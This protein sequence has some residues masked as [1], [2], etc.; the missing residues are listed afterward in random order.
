MIEGVFPLLS[1][2][3]SPYTLDVEQ[4]VQGGM[5]HLDFYVQRTGGTDFAFSASNF[6]VFLTSQYLNLFG[7]TVDY[8]AA[9]PWDASY[10]PLSYRSLGTTFTGQF[11]NLNILPQPPSMGGNGQP[12]TMTRTRIGRLK[13]PITDPSGCNTLTWRWGPIAVNRWD[14]EDIKPYATLI[15]PP[16]CFP[17][18]EAPETPSITASGATT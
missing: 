13:V 18:C 10:D 4:K 15:T 2:A 8:S 12:V 3:Q 5:L 1:F 14:G 6:S 17:L 16:P 11:V 9:G 7:T